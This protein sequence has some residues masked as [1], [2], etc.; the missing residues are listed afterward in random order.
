[1][2][3]LAP[4]LAVA[5]VLLTL[6]RAGVADPVFPPGAMTI[7]SGA[8]R[9]VVVFDRDGTLLT[10]LDAKD[11]N[12][13]QDLVIGADGRIHLIYEKRTVV[14]D[15][16]FQTLFTIEES[17]QVE[18]GAIGPNGHLF[19]ADT[20]WI[21]EFDE[22]GAKVGETPF[23][24]GGLGRDLAFGPDGLLYLASPTG[25][26]I[27]IVDPSGRVAGAITA[28]ELIAPVGLEFAPDGT[29]WVAQA[30]TVN[31]AAAPLL[32]F[33]GEGNLLAEIG[34]GSGVN[35]AHD[36][37]FG[38]DGLLYVPDYIQDRVFRFSPDGT[39]VDFVADQDGLDYPYGV[40]FAPY[41]FEAK[42][43]GK[44]RLANGEDE[45]IKEEGTLSILAGSGTAMLWLDPEEELT[46]LLGTRA[47]V[48]R[49]F[50]IPEED[51]DGEKR[52]LHGVQVSPRAL[53]VGVASLGLTLDGD[54]DD[55]VH[56]AEK[57][58][59]TLQISGAAG[60]FL[61]KVKTDDLID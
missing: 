34:V 27:T 44:V 30:I 58:K 47:V 13:F 60:V 24:V 22:T 2:K 18:R 28:P 48:V 32:R 10:R 25:P 55:G 46:E 17:S 59:G 11:A 26:E 53:Q 12:G 51:D 9:E 37:T 57:A 29:L 1:M 43:K 6:P 15:A 50:E 3:P 61:G 33:D 45:K 8:T 20:Y 5:A 54:V 39:L 40:R 56:E 31:T 42:I 4:S 49:G 14:K 38:P 36:V 52:T 23:G 7:V 16:E 19:L 35:W 21:R 41:R